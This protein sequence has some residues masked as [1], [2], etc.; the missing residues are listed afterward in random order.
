VTAPRILALL[1]AIAL[2]SAPTTVGAAQPSGAA[3]TQDRGPVR[4]ELVI[5]TELGEG[6]AVI[7][8]RVR[9][10]AD[11]LL[12]KRE[13]LPA[14]S[15][16]DPR[17]VVRIEPLGETPGYKC[18]V[19][20]HDA[21]GPIAGTESATTCEVCTE[22]ELVDHVE[23]AID[24]VVPQIPAAPAPPPE[25]KVTP[26]TSEITPDITAPDKSLTPIGKAGIGVA[27]LGVVGI[28]AG[29][30]V[31]TRPTKDVDM[32]LETERTEFRVPGIAVLAGGLGVLVVGLALIGVDRHRAKKRGTQT[33][34]RF[35]VL[36]F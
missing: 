2:A 10:R 17:I 3:P 7:T 18:N 13:V 9:V 35:G 4:A 29:A 28:V 1:T 21:S 23:K 36:R 25:P 12:R 30:V 15:D 20:I 33:A 27:A 5:Q 32:E 31:V 11:G 14:R 22:N 24:G 26:T 34:S 6:S 19:S 16:Q 8:D